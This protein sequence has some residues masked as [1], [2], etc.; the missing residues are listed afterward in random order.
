MNIERILDEIRYKL[1]DDIDFIERCPCGRCQLFN[2][3]GRRGKM[4]TINWYIAREILP[5]GIY[6]NLGD[7]YKFPPRYDYTANY[8]MKMMEM[9]RF[10]NMPPMPPM[11]PPPND[12][13]Q[14][15]NAVWEER[16]EKPI[17][18]VNKK[19]KSLYWSYYS[20]NKEKAW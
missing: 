7:R 12:F 9:Q 11:P 1:G 13:Q 16:I 8:Q 17:I 6:M 2:V 14:R 3:Y 20:K 15:Y 19:L 4:L 5:Q 10:Y 18:K